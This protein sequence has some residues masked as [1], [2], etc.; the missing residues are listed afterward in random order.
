MYTK[1]Y[2]GSE[3]IGCAMLQIPKTGGEIKLEPRQG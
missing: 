1:I 3:E 2:D